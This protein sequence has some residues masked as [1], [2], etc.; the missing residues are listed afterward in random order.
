MEKDNLE[1][2]ILLF[3]K[4]WYEKHGSNLEG[5]RHMVARYTGLSLEYV[6]DEVVLEWLIEAFFKYC[7][8]DD[9]KRELRISCL[10]YRKY[11]VFDKP[12]LVPISDRIEEMVGQL[13]VVQI[14]AYGDNTPL[15]DIGEP[16]YT[17][18]EKPSEKGK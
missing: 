14:L 15:T 16:D 18:F 5:L 6:N 10:G 7:R 13:G 1:R 12:T 11:S 8:P 3:S 9:I 2:H 17:Q 4:G